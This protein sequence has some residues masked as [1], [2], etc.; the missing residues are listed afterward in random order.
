MVFSKKI[1]AIEQFVTVGSIF[2]LTEIFDDSFIIQTCWKD[3]I[4]M[5]QKESYQLKNK[6]SFLSL[7]KK[8][9]SKNIRVQISKLK[10]IFR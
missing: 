6:I 5:D 3:N 2:D 8:Y 4:D 10:N 1:N 7:V 9:F